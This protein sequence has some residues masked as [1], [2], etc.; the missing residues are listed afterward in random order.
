MCSIKKGTVLAKIISDCKAIIVDEAPMTH[1]CAFEAVDRT[2][3]DI[4]CFNA[5]FG[6]IPTLLCGDFRQILPVV[7][8][9]TRAN[10]VDASLKHSYL[11]KFIHIF[12]LTTNMRVHLRG[13]TQ[14]GMFAEYLLSIG[15]GT[16]PLTELP[17]V[18]TIPEFISCTATLDEMKGKIYPNLQEHAHDEKWLSEC[19]I[20][21]S[22]NDTVNHINASLIHQFPGD[23]IT[24][25]SVDSTISDDEAVHFPTEFLN[26]IE[27]SGLPP[28]EL[29]L[30]KGCPIILLR[31]LDPPRLMNGTRCIMTK[32]TANLIEA[33]ISQGPFTGEVVMIPRIPLIPSDSELPFQF[34]RVQFPVRPCFAMTINKSQGQ[35]LKEVGIDLSTPCFCHGM[36]YVAQ[37]R[38]GSHNSLVVHAPGRVTRNVVYS[39]VLL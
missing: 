37:S 24:Y 33:K 10:I 39:E 27:L 22:L 9:G 15:D 5:P 36:L 32:G 20:L 35:T 4:Q 18:I 14:A 16:Y 11:W 3:R 34:R 23:V 26:S 29:T 28:H 31:S 21:A 25:R 19:A 30:K 7:W 13:D 6:G 2:L 8:N 38:T 12:H 1:R 17:S